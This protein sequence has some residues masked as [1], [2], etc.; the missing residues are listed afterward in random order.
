M[1]DDYDTFVEKKERSKI[2][3]QISEVR[4][5]NNVCWM[6]LL[7]LAFQSNPDEAKKIFKKITENDKQI[8]DLSKELCK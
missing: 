1:K 7:K 8:N 3:D 5:N 2:I 6:D 4:K